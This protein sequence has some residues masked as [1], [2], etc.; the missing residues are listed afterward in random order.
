MEFFDSNH[1]KVENDRQGECVKRAL[2]KEKLK[3]S[4]TKLLDARSIVDWCSL[5][6]SQTW[7]LDS[8]VCRFSW[9]IEQGSIGDRP[10]CATVRDS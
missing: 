1:K 6:L 7:T 8:V 3:I 5:T 2:V 9:L 10:D 4:T